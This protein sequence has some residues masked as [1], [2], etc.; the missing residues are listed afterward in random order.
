[1]KSLI[2]INEKKETDINEL[3]SMIIM[4][5]KIIG[6]YRSFT[7]ELNRNEGLNIQNLK[8]NEKIEK[9]NK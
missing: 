9:I 4:Q 8:W 5:Q 3:H 6:K 2:E 7:A 1:M